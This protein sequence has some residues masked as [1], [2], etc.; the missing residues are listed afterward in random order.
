MNKIFDFRHSGGGFRISDVQLSKYIGI[1]HMTSAAE[2]EGFF[3]NAD[4]GEEALADVSKNL[5]SVP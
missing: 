2:G 4:E 3:P 5:N 1:V